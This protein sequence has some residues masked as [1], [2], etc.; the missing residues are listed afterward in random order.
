ME[1]PHF[2]ISVTAMLGVVACAAVN[3][4]LFRVSVLAGIIGLNVT[5]HVIIAALCHT[6]GVDRRSPGAAAP[7]RAGSG[8][9]AAPEPPAPTHR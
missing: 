3:F 7:A 5:K 4:W 2:Q 9:G 6:L 8:T 1:R